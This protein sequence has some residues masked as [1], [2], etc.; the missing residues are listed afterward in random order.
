MTP[1]CASKVRLMRWR[2]HNKIFNARCVTDPATKLDNMHAPG[3]IH[4]GG[5]AA[6]CKLGYEKLVSA[7]HPFLPLAA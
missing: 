7:F 6:F 5:V 1:L 4:K 3:L 2:A